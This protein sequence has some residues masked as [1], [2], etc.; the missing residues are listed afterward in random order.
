MIAA[1]NNTFKLDTR[2]T[3]YIFTITKH[4][5]PNHIYY[6][7]RLPT[8]DLEA[9]QMKNTICFGSEV[10]YA[11]GYCLE[12]RLLEY[13]G[14]G[15]G[16]FRHSPIECVM[17]DGTFVTDFAYEGHQITDQAYHDDCG[18]PFAAGKGETL[19]LWFHDKK[20]QNIKLIL[21][22]T[23]FYDCDVICRNAELRN[24]GEAEIALRRFMS[25][26][27]DLPHSEYRLLT[28][29]GG[30]AKEAHIQLSPL[31]AGLHVNDSTT[32]T[33][34]NRHNPAFALLGRGADE[35][36]GEVLGFN[37]IYSGNH[38]SAVEKTNQNMLR[39][40]LGISPHC[41]SWKLKAGD[42]FV[43][44]QAVMTYA[45]GGINAMAANMHDF[46]NN[47]IIPER[48]RFAERPVVLNNWEATFFNFN[49]RKILNLAKQ[50]EDL[51]VEMMVLDDGWFGKR[52]DD[53]AGLGDWTVNEKKLP[54]GIRSL[55]RQI[56]KLGLQFGLWFEPESVNEDSELY[57]A[58]PDW[59]IQI[60]DR[61]PSRGRNQLV[62]DLTRKEVR[63]YI[64]DAV[65]QA[66]HGGRIEYVKWDFNR[67]LSDVFSSGLSD[68][69][70]FYHRYVLGLYEILRRI[71]VEKNRRILL[72]GCASGGN[73]FD[74]GMLCFA[75]QIWTSD[76]TDGRER[77]EIQ[78]GMYC[79]YP[80]SCISN[81][82]SQ[83]PNQQTLRDVPLAT[84]FNVAA[85]GVLGYELDVEELS[86][87]ER[88]QVKEQIAF[89][90]E[91]RYT[92]QFGRF[93]RYFP[94]ENTRESWQME[95]NGEIIAGIYNLSYE[96]APERDCL[97][98]LAARPGKRYRMRSVKQQIQLKRFGGLL[99]HVLPFK[100]KPDGKAMELA[101]NHFALTDGQEEY[102]CSGE[103]LNGGVQLAMQYTGTGYHKDLR[104]LGDFGSSLYL[105]TEAESKK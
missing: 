82:V 105:V 1:G 67:N 66:L 44:P 69:G 37:L 49:S 100:L 27:V 35:T 38:Y 64:V 74:L 65:C 80:P 47:H 24:D 8:A 98:I 77:L 83:T 3:S 29:A 41:F 2:N 85:F 31:S 104:L 75:P 20:F 68:Q 45:L 19:T 56:H 60:P 88:K 79:F 61:E 52:N 39:V 12:S 6:G 48:F 33:S 103:A 102:T 91:H 54:G 22:Y 40:A 10:E 95:G 26:M 34:S 55:S 94:K 59:S 43:T 7:R 87:Q 11:P 42:K 50:A 84:R 46:V 96:T 73:R 99:K 5:H 16:D 17:P 51:G 63:D 36:H 81:H 78:R 23:V 15:K 13:S 9:L 30:W 92:L 86:A 97:Q 18:L 4:G 53:K 90:K 28:L 25:A 72:E 93:S 32:G 14:I 21:H 58:H 62:L 101:D 71:F 57:R 76:D 89:Y 70:E